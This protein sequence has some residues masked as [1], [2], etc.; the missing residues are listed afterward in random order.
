MEK[1]L[2]I[3]VSLLCLIFITPSGL[4]QRGCCSWH[5][6]VAKCDRNAGRQVCRDGTYSPSCLCPLNTQAIPIVNN[7]APS[8]DFSQNQ[9]VIALIY[10][11][12]SNGVSTN[13]RPLSG[14][15]CNSLHEYEKLA[16]NGDIAAQTILGSL[17]QDGQCVEKNYSK[18]IEWYSLVL[19]NSKIKEKPIQFSA[20][21]DNQLTLLYWQMGNDSMATSHAY[22]AVFKGSTI[23]LTLLG[24]MSYSG[25]DYR[26]AFGFFEKAAN[27]GEPFAQYKLA[28]MYS[29]GE[30]A[31]QDN[32]K[33]Y[34]WVAVAIANGLPKAEEI[35]AM[36]LRG[37]L[38]D[39]LI[40]SHELDQ[41]KTLAKDFYTKY[42]MFVE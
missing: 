25:K 42:K 14:Q 24:G 33:A 19:N 3:I 41:A 34:A 22:S 4:A 27:R 5:G 36:S 10:T 39:Q 38:T 35:D 20:W 21:V 7:N 26:V 6:G 2:C 16:V 29:T 37:S 40:Q 28:K 23:G 12:E 11:S 13:P 32:V 31:L 1:K 15:F 18:A 17:Y 30:G 8:I 9:R